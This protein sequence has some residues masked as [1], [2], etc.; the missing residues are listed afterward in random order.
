MT[1]KQ[2]E[3]HMDQLERE[4]RIRGLAI[5]RHPSRPA[6]RRGTPAT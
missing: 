1:T 5:E 6:V 2:K 3:A 4:A